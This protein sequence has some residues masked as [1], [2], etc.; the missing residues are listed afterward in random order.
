MSEVELER[1]HA[2]LMRLAALPD[3]ELHALVTSLLAAE[4]DG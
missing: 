4:S 1:L 2:G 3:K